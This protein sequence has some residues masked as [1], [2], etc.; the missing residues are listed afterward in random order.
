MSEKELL[1]TYYRAYFCDKCG[2]VE[3]PGAITGKPDVK[4]S[5]CPEC[6]E[7]KDFGIRVGRFKYKNSRA[8]YGK[9]TYTLTKFVPGIDRQE[10]KRRARKKGQ[11][12]RPER[13]KEIVNLTERACF[14]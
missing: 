8:W 13:Q 1:S 9:K 7:E 14:G 3:V 11:K 5:C 6:G 4:M 2:N 12:E 10:Q